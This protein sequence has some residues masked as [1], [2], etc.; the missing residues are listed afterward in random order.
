VKLW[1][2][3]NDRI[4]DIGKELGAECDSVVIV[5]TRY[6]GD[7]TR[8]SF[9]KLGNAY[10]CIASAEELVVEMRKGDDSSEATS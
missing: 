8:Q 7:R 9:V 5:V 2:Q 6:E 10:A 1:Q 3:I 4:A